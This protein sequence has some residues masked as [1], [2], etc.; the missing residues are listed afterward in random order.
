MV[1]NLEEKFPFKCDICDR[2]FKTE[3]GFVWINPAG[4]CPDCYEKTTITQKEQKYL[5]ILLVIIT[6]LFFMFLGYFLI[7]FSELFGYK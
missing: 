2:E 5:V 4:F 3:K 7:N 6:P 1:T